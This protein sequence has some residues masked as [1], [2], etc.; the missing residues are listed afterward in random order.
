MERNVGGR[1]RIARAVLA[2]SLAAVAVQALRAGNRT[3]AMLAA[4]VALGFS[5]NAVTC[6]CGLNRTLGIDT[7]SGD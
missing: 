2:V 6:F 7:T 5:I 1:D 4:V 3:R